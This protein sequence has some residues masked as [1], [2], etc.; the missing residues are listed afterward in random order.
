MAVFAKPCH[1][2]IPPAF[3]NVKR[4]HF[5]RIAATVTFGAFHRFAPSKISWALRA[6]SVCNLR[7]TSSHPRHTC[8][9]RVATC[10]S[11]PL[12]LFHHVTAH[13]VAVPVRALALRAYLRLSWE[14]YTPVVS[15][16]LAVPRRNCEF[17]SH[18]TPPLAF[19]SSVLP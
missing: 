8:R 9:P 17:S 16:P 11:F 10:T 6:R 12:P 7:G 1:P 3:L 15:A 13:I 19:L 5:S 2:V 18:S 14:P 4:Y